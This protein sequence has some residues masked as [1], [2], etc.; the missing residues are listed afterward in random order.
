MTKL[1]IVC[2][3]AIALAV[4][5]CGD[6]SSSDA[7]APGSRASTTEQ[8]STSTTSTGSTTPSKAAKPPP[9]IPISEEAKEAGA[10]ACGDIDPKEAI[11]RFAASARKA[12]YEDVAATRKG[13][14]TRVRQLRKAD[15]DA[16]AP[17]VASAPLAAALYAISQPRTQ[18][19]GAYQ[20]CLQQM[21]RAQ[22]SEG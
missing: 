19:G 10:K 5:G 12:G 6:D 9:A 13:L 2:L 3:A 1:T 8:G 4:S 21:V 17:A 11:D 18:R 22:Q 14:L 7:T 20:G 16:E 15:G